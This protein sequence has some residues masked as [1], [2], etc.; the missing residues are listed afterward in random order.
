MV[1]INRMKLKNKPIIWKLK[2][3]YLKL[4]HRSSNYDGHNRQLI[5]I[6]Q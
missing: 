2:E 1:L 4:T 6:R 3:I 5:F